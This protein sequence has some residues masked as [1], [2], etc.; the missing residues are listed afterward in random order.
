MLIQHPVIGHAG[1][2]D[3]SHRVCEAYLLICRRKTGVPS[4]CAPKPF[5]GKTEGQLRRYRIQ[6][7]LRV[8]DD[9]Q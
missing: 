9:G 2:L 3:H 4:A 5:Y 7:R 1:N 8:A 6:T